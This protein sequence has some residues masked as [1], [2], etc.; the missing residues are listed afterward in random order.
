MI[1]V[2]VP[3]YQAE[4]VLPRCIESILQQSYRSLEVILVDDG[5]TDGSGSIC[6]SYAKKDSRVKVLHKENA[7]V[8][9]ARNAGIAIATGEYVQF[10]DSDDYLEESCCEVL[11]T[12]AKNTGAKMVLCGFHHW[13]YGKDVVKV[14]KQEGT[15]LF[16][17]SGEALL[18]LYDQGFL[19]MPWNKLFC[20]ASIHKPF[21]VALS[22]GEDFLFN[23]EYMRQFDQIALVQK[24]L[25]HYVQEGNPNSLSAR[26]R[27]NKL[28]ISLRIQSEMKR[29]YEE[30]VGDLP[31]RPVI[32]E[33]FLR[34]YLDE[35]EALPFDQKLSLAEKRRIILRYSTLEQ[36]EEAGKRVK[37]QQIDYR[38]LH[39]FFRHHAA[40]MV[41]LLAYMRAFVITILRRGK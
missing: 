7:G 32:E 20:R 25:Y 39:W 28:E 41:L 29:F 27:E 36:I 34:E 37:F 8:S 30:K 9:A 11:W 22:L 35:L 19:N 33:R 5:A 18:E 24:P 10:V 26:K 4:K 40:T 16:S 17:E 12:T 38:L 1:S 23:L 13:Y 21:D 6:D 31:Q 2:I 15:F 3:V 14:P